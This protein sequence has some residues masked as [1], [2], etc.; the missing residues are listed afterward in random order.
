LEKDLSFFLSKIESG[1]SPSLVVSEF[2]L[3]DFVPFALVSSSLEAF[4]LIAKSYCKVYA[5]LFSPLSTLREGFGSGNDLTGSREDSK[6]LFAPVNRYPGAFVSKY[7]SVD[8]DA[9]IFPGAYVGAGV[10]VGAGSIVYPSVVLLDGVSVGK[11]SRIFSGTVVGSPGFGYKVEAAGCRH[12]PHVG[13]VRIGDNVDIGA[14]CSVDRG[15]I[16]DTVIEDGVKID[17]SVH[18]A[19]NVKIGRGTIILAQTG[20][21]GNVVIGNY[22]QIGGQVAIRDGIKVGN[23]VKV[24]AKSAV[25]G[26]LE[27]NAVVSG[28]PAVDFF[29]WK[30]M[31][32]Y[33]SK[34]SEL[35]KKTTK[36]AS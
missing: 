6:Q 7:A 17:N 26:D 27:D 22:C 15:T 5:G 32:V 11:N 3:P 28:I 13:S 33:I 23:N 14:N 36:P 34:L 24:V 18:V 12:I 2:S 30:R 21:A 25:V 31:V 1:K 20:I 35:F 8:R 9:V 4:E 10:S 19:H 29:R 16:D